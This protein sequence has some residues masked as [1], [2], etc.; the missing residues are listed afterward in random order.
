MKLPA[1]GQVNSL[2]PTAN[3]VGKVLPMLSLL[4]GSCSSD[5]TQAPPR[6]EEAPAP[7]TDADRHPTQEIDPPE[8][9]PRAT[10]ALVISCVDDEARV[11]TYYLP[12]HNGVQSCVIGY[13]ICS[14][15][16]WGEC[17]EGVTVDGGSVAGTGG[18]Y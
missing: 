11:C 17:V 5:T 6:L 15:N 4:S 10:A 18:S 9:R 16:Q 12:A 3:L 2:R 13:Q 14:N 7:H 8:D 1:R